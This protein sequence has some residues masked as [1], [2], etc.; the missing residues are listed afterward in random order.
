M[1]QK[2]VH[3]PKTQDGKY[4]GAKHQKGVGGNRQNSRDAVQSK[5]DIGKLDHHQGNEQRRSCGY[6]S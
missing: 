3:R 1:G 6:M 5:Q 4:I 2:E